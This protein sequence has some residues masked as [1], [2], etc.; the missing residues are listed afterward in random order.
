VDRRAGHAAALAAIAAVSGRSAPEAPAPAP[1]RRRRAPRARPSLQGALL[2]A[3]AA[4]ELRP[5]PACP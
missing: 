5:A 1:E 2:L 3:R 4:L